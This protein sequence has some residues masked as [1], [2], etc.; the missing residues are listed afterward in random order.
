MRC[1]RCGKETQVTTMSWFSTET[2]CPDC[3]EAEKNHPD[4]KLAVETECAACKSGNYNFPG[5]GWPGASGR[6]GQ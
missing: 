2:I 4:Y 6:V 5:V 3:S 1:E